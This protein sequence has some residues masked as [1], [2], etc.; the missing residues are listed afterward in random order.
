METLLKLSRLIDATSE[1]VGKAVMWLIPVAA[2]VAAGNAIARKAFDSGSNA[3]MELQYH[4]FA[5]VVMFAAA[6]TL[7]R[8][9]HV[10]ID[11]LAG[12]FSRRTQAVMEI[13]GFLLFFAPFAYLMITMSTP[14]A[15]EVFG[16]GETS[17][18]T[19]GLVKWTLYATVPL[20]FSLLS[21]Q[22]LSETIKRIGFLAG[23]CEDPAKGTKSDEERLLEDLRKAAEGGGK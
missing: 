23:R 5:A 3:F 22:A 12:K 18:N 10:R 1:A 17:S 19:G 9:G 16:T 13:A 2:V 11:L 20:G 14:L 7:R 4:L 6:Y 15:I 8:Q 21:A